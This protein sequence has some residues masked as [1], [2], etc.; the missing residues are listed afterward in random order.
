MT[1]TTLQ[2]FIGWC[3][4]I[5][6]G[7]LT[8]WFLSFVLAKEWMY[9]LHGRWFNIS[10]ERFD[11]IHYGGMAGYKLAIWLFNLAPFI[12]LHLVR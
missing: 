8:L 2:A 3:A 6:F 4:L 10:R 11:A 12:A 7:L 9:R 5:N 1:A